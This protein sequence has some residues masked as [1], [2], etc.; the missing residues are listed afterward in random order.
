MTHG[1]SRHVVLFQ[2]NLE[3]GLQVDPAE[4]GWV[5]RSVPWQK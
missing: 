3:L 5:H 2:E 1:Y 4:D